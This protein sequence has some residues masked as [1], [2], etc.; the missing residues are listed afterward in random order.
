MSGRT[1]TGVILLCF[2]ALV[3]YALPS[4]AE[5][6]L[7]RLLTALGIP[8]NPGQVKAPGDAYASGDIIL[9]RPGQGA[10][11]QITSEGG[12][13]SPVFG[14]EGEI[15]ALKGDTLV[16]IPVAGGTA[17]ELR[18]IE[19]A[20]KLL[21]LNKD[22]PDVIVALVEQDGLIALATVA[23]A[24]NETKRYAHDPASAQDAAL[25][26]ALQEE[27][28]DYGSI[29]LYLKLESKQGPTGRTIEWTDVYLKRGDAAPQNVSHCDG[30]NCL[31][32]ALAPDTERVVFVRSYN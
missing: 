27:A 14:R 17:R 31:Q 19:G 23:R 1:P 24:G 16:S 6:V 26:A 8:V 13:R 30:S 22:N 25:L 20:H 29:K 2:F 4:H 7:S 5:G 11:Q 18:A 32:P 28:R 12:Y 15:L 9:A 21:G 3:S 10:P